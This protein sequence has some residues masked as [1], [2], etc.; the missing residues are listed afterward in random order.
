MTY[1]TTKT[2]GHNQGLS[3]AFRQWRATHSHC[4]WIHG[5]ALSVTLDFACDELDDKN[6]GVD[7]G[8]LKEVKQ[9]L[10]D[11]FDHKTV[12]AADDPQLEWFVEADN[13]G[14]LDLS[15]LPAVGCEKFAEHIGRWVISWLHRNYG[16]RVSL[17]SVTV[18][19]HEGNS[20]S[21]SRPFEENY[22]EFEHKQLVS[23]NG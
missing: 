8:G 1:Y 7:Y 22:A 14:I 2:F 6:W 5:Y 17:V 12:V 11:S 20:A 15:I 4:S 3:C 10:V 21:W 9:F 16:D 23:N 18:A 19:E 13:R